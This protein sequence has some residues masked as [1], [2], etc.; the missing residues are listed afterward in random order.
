MKNSPTKS[1]SIKKPI[2][3]PKP[4]Q[5]KLGQFRGLWL[6]PDAFSPEEMAIKS[7]QLATSATPDA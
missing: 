5:R 7:P 1:A 2:A 6:A 4:K 3:L